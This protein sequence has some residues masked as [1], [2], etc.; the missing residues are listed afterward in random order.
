VQWLAYAAQN[1][2]KKINHALILAGP[3]G[4]GKDSLLEPLIT[5]LGQDN[6]QEVLP[7]TVMG[8]FN[9]FLKSVL[10]RV[11]ELHG[12][13]DAH[14]KEFGNRMKTIVAAPP[15]QHRIDQKYINE[16]HVP[17]ITK[18]ICTT[19]ET[20]SALYLNADARRYYIAG[21]RFTKEQHPPDF[22]D[23][24]H[25]W[26]ESGG[27]QNVAAYLLNL[28]VSGFKPKAPPPKTAAWYQMVDHSVHPETMGFQDLIER[29]SDENGNPPAVV[30]LEMLREEASKVWDEANALFEDPK[31]RTRLS[32]RLDDVGYMKAINPDAAKSGGRWRKSNRKLTLFARKE[33]T[34]REQEDACRAFLKGQE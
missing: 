33:M 28:D 30:S 26:G 5:A 34:N 13:S 24:Y 10:L 1:P 11:S 9:T 15:A 12:I 17:N 4:I 20:R 32:Y 31:H 22:F 2:G 23:S 18:V 29:L 6:C 3:E 14:K 21:T 27:F 7:E 16:F 25:D 19:N 8:R